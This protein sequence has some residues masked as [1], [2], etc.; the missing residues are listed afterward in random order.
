M[1][2]VENPLL[3]LGEE[4]LFYFDKNF[5]FHEGAN[6]FVLMYNSDV[7]KHPSTTETSLHIK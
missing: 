7:S 5:K 6:N 4:N 1:L 3:C 2:N